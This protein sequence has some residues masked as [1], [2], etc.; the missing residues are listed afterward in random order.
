[1]VEIEYLKEGEREPT[2]RLVEPYSFERELPVWR[3]HTWDRTVGEPRTYRLDRMRPAR[4]TDEE[5]EPRPDFDPNYLRDPR[6]A[7]VLYSPAVA[8]Y[9]VERGARPLADGSALAEL[10]YQTEDWLVGE[11]LADRGDAVVLEPADGAAAWLSARARSPRA[12]WP[13]GSSAPGGD[14]SRSGDHAPR[15]R[16]VRRLNERARTRRSTSVSKRWRRAGSIPV[17][18]SSSTA[19]ACGG[20]VYGADFPDAREYAG[21]RADP[22]TFVVRPHARRARGRGGRRAHSRPPGR[23]QDG[24]QRRGGG[25]DRPARPS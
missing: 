14:E 21:V 7:R 20:L 25:G 10:P 4:L 5:F 1:M 13:R 6:V 23:A 18:S 15:A 19:S 8:R 11:V 9:K 12:G 2:R 22:R 16:S 24:T 17:R 3:V